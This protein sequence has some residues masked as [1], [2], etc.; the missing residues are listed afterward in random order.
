MP[1]VLKRRSQ[2]LE[3]GKF[4]SR[5]KT[6]ALVSICLKGPESS[7]SMVG[8]TAS[9][10]VGGAVVRNKAKRRLRAL[11]RELDCELLPGYFFVFI[12]TSETAVCNFACLRSDFL[13]CLRKSKSRADNANRI[14]R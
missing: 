6:S 3:V 4:G 14:C 8:Y 7:V 13:Y 1:T 9:A 12:A 11:V 5:A 10:K 2:F